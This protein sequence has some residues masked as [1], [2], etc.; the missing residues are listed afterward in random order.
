MTKRRIRT[1]AFSRLKLSAGLAGLCLAGVAGV[2][3]AGACDDLAKVAL[4][5]VTITKAVEFA[6]G[7]FRDDTRAD[8]QIKIQPGLPAFCRVRGIT[9]PTSDSEIEFEIWLPVETRWTRRLHMIGNGAY[10]GNIMYDM[11]A[12][13][14]KAGDVA[15]A[16]NTGHKGRELTFGIGHPEKIKDFAGRS[17]HESVVAAKAITTAYYNAP[18]SYAY[19]SGCSTGGY[20]GLAEAQRYPDD[21]DGI[22]SGAPGN[23]RTN[24]TLAF[25]WNYLANHRPGDDVHAIL[26]DKDLLLINKAAVTA[27]D[28]DDG[29]VD[30]VISDPRTCRFDIARLQC[31]DGKTDGCLTGEQVIAARKMYSGPRDRRT[32]QSLYPGYSIGSE[33]IIGADGGAHPGWSGYWHNETSD[34]EPN[35][36]DLFRGWVFNDPSW[37]WWHFNWAS[38]VD[39]VHTTLSPIFD[40]NDPNLDAFNARKGKLIMFMGWADPVGAAQEGINYYAAVE[41]R[42]PGNAA[43][44]QKKTQDFLRLYMVP[45]MAHCEGGPGVSR[46][47]SATRGNAPLISDARHDMIVALQDWVEQK[48]PPQ[49]IVASKLSGE[50]PAKPEVAFE[51][52]LCVYP[53]V[54]RYQGG[55]KTS[56]ASFR[57]VV[58]TKSG[59]AS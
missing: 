37:N 14:I 42:M 16:T 41:G 19:F 9:R 8:A 18:A 46:F 12:A 20:Q 11:M 24:L 2:A 57:C 15:V 58:P 44:R 36:L 28:K 32:G 35:R 47:S 1:N 54:A 45:G 21:F 17:V 5:N 26:S 13:R 50:N 29:V 4:P 53:Q 48:R 33:G 51:R 40:A 22:L 49:A 3:N 43:A 10:S 56:A 6:G 30:Q 27:C 34:N 7:N 38:D 23:N 25:L 39:T 52:L 59:R 31:R 55:D